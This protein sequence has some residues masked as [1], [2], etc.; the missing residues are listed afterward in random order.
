MRWTTLSRHGFTQECGNPSETDCHS[1]VIVSLT[2]YGTQDFYLS[3]S[4]YREISP[5]VPCPIASIPPSVSLSHSHQLAT[6]HH[7][8]TH[9]FPFFKLEIVSFSRFLHPRLHVLGQT[10]HVAP[11]I[12]TYNDFP[13]PRLLGHLAPD[14]ATVGFDSFYFNIS[15]FSVS[16][17]LRSL[18][19]SHTLLYLLRFCFLLAFCTLHRQIVSTIVGWPYCYASTNE[20]YLS[21][22]TK[23]VRSIGALY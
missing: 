20:S 2:C 15:V 9:R 8:P 4:L 6:R 16:G 14:E 23:P 10:R 22:G 3:G 5:L 11:A 18:A 13:P 1:S 21:G 17:L 7:F 19:V 12:I